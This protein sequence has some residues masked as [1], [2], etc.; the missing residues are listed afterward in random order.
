MTCKRE[1]AEIGAALQ[2]LKG[3]SSP[4]NSVAFSS[5]N[6]QFVS[7]SGDNTVWLWDATTGAAL[8][9]LEGHSDW[10]SSIA[11]SAYGK[12]LSTLHVFNNCLVKGTTNIL[13][14]LSRP[15]SID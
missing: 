15:H 9:M 7:D 13:W 11:F 3:H 1:A 12:L 2:T 5:D 14:L 6:K 8:Q 10:V 4:V